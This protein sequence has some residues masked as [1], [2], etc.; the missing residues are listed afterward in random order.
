MITGYVERNAHR[1]DWRC[2]QR[3]FY[4]IMAL[5]FAF[6]AGGWLTSIRVQEQN[7]PYLKRSTNRFE[8]VQ[9]VAGPNPEAAIKCERRR[10]DVAESVATDAIISAL[11]AGATDAP[12]LNRI[13]DCPPAPTAKK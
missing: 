1:F 12:D 2:I 3:N 5:L 13:P 7:L 8:Q 6:A 4:W 11:T 9:R 10:G